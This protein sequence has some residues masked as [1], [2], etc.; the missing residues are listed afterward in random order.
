MTP[1]SL[2]VQDRD[3]YFYLQLYGKDKAPHC[4]K[5]LLS[6]AALLKLGSIFSFVCLFNLTQTT[7]AP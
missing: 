1:Q 2:H 6:A 5:D 4:T 7:A 3:K